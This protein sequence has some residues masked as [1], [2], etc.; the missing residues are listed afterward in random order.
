MICSY[1]I[2]RVISSLFVYPELHSESTMLRGENKVMIHWMLRSWFLM[3]DGSWHLIIH[4]SYV[5]WIVLLRW[6]SMLKWNECMITRF[7]DLSLDWN[8]FSDCF[9]KDDK[10]VKYYCSS[11]IIVCWNKKIIWLSYLRL[12]F[13]DS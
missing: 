9:W 2:S 7:L 5:Q 3:K 1:H 8:L 12:L 11:K 4:P 10:Y 13:Q 6:A